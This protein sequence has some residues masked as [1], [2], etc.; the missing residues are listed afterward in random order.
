MKRFLNITSFSTWL[1]FAVAACIVT[2]L[3]TA[4]S[5][6][7]GNYDYND[8][9][10]IG[11]SSTADSFAI[12]QNDTLNIQINLSQTKPA[13]Q[14]SYEWF[15]IQYTSSN[16]NPPEYRL[17]TT[18]NL[19]VQIKVVPG[20]YKLVNKVKDNQTGVSFYKYFILRVLPAPWGG[21]GWLVLQDQQSLH[22]G[23]DLS[24]II[25][26]DAVSHGDV[27]HNLYFQANGRKLPTGTN[28]MSVI[29]YSHN[30]G[31]QKVMFG[32][33]GGG[34][35]VKA[36]DFSDSSYAQNWFLN[37]PSSI[38][39]GSNSAV[40]GGTRETI[41]VND[42]LYYRTVANVFLAAG[43]VLFGAPLLGSWELSPIVMRFASLSGHYVTL[44]DKKN[45]SFLAMNI[46]TNSLVPTGRPDIP[47][48][49]FPAYTGAAAA[50]LPT[51]SGYDLN[52][53]RHNLLDAHNISNI[54]NPPTTGAAAI[55]NC[56]FRNDAADSTWVIQ[57]PVYL[58]YTNNNVTG[59]YYLNPAKCPGINSAMLFANPTF[60]PAPGTFYYAVDNKI[61]TCN[62]SAVQGNSTATEGFNFPSGTV[63]KAM[64]LFESEYSG[65]ST[66]PRTPLPATEGR[67]LVVATDETASGGG[68][69]VYFININN[70]GSLQ[71]TAADKYTG[72]NKIV[73][74]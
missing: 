34:V 46:E 3:I 14:L 54:V 49:H 22:N 28:Y 74:L 65:P 50:L 45:R 43:P 61:Y 52:N 30:T 68:H 25:S 58:A 6:D 2:V 4:C 21:E 11:I 1:R 64:K 33:P 10:R 31:L 62:L 53:I 24:I 17:A 12:R 73:D 38:N 66:L 20:L 35:E 47:N 7:L 18:A 44:Y 60:L 70:N 5:K 29:N 19:K 57:L 71:T 39:V 55:W 69:N 16:P 15:L 48:Q 72:F 63:I 27:Y 42:Q 67:V 23:N 37:A 59:R 41:I 51:G 26:R 32:Y 9:N 8:A 36:I 40:A 56:F 13:G